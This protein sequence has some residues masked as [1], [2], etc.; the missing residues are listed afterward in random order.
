LSLRHKFVLDKL[1][2][3]K[4]IHFLSCMYTS[5][6]HSTSRTAYQWQLSTWRKSW[7]W[8]EICDWNVPRFMVFCHQFILGFDSID[9]V[10]L[11]DGKHTSMFT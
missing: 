4:T 1:N 7:V 8:I 3:S 5:H 11:Y 6:D 2:G 10:G 9:Y